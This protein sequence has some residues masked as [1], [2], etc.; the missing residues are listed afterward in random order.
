MLATRGTDPRQIVDDSSRRLR[1]TLEVHRDYGDHVRSG[2][3]TLR[4]LKREELKANIAIGVCS[5]IFFCVAAHVAHKRITTSNT[6]TFIVRPAVRTV[7]LPFRVLRAIARAIRS[8]F[9]AGKVQHSDERTGGLET[10]V[11]HSAAA[12]HPEVKETLEHGQLVGNA[13]LEYP[14]ATDPIVQ[15][16]GLGGA[17]EL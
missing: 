3:G 14:P 4:D 6:A 5:F 11:D 17:D 15:T 7:A 9:P 12:S 10:S 2:S 1:K 16:H 8:C 13:N